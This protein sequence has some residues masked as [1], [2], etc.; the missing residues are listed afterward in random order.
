VLLP[1]TCPICHR[2]GKA[3]CARCV[4][5]LERSPVLPPPAGV[6]ELHALLRYDGAGRDLVT[7]L[8]YRSGRDVLAWA[9]AAM[10]RLAT[11]PR[12]AIVTWAPTSPRRR[13]ARGFDQAEL[14]ARAVARRWGVPCAPLLRRRS[15]APQTGATLAARRLGPVFEGARRPPTG[16]VIVIDDVATSGATLEAAARA[17]RASGATRVIAL[18]LARTPLKSRPCS[19]DAIDDAADQRTSDQVDASTQR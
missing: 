6:D 2:P 14:L 8:K 12:G 10:A 11:P 7:A 3:P 17:L 16:T 9:A 15:T 4:A 19:T 18:T 1:P 13:R 5:A